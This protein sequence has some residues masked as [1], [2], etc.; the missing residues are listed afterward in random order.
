VTNSS[1]IVRLEAWQVAEQLERR[2]LSSVEVVR[3][4][5]D[6]A[7]QVDGR[8]GAFVRRFDREALA[9]A[10]RADEA[11]AVVKASGPCTAC[12]SA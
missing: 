7:D 3:A 10:E 5:L 4:L 12:Q 11:R 8:L 6:R 9:Q 2:E 1:E